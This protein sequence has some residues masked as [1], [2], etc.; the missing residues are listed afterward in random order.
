M[1]IGPFVRLLTPAL[2]S[3]SASS[4]ATQ[5]SCAAWLSH[6]AKSA[7]W[8]R[9]HS[10]AWVPESSSPKPEAPAEAT[11]EPLNEQ[12]S[13]QSQQQQQQ[14]RKQQTPTVEASQHHQ[15]RSLTSSL[16]TQSRSHSQLTHSMTAADWRVNET[17]LLENMHSLP[18]KHV[19]HVLSRMVM[20]PDPEANSLMQTRST[21]TPPTSMQYA[22]SSRLFIKQAAVSLRQHPALQQLLA[23]PESCT[24]LAEDSSFP[25][26]SRISSS[27]V[28]PSTGPVISLSQLSDQGGLSNSR[29]L[30]AGQTRIPAA[31]KDSSNTSTIST[32]SV[33]SLPPDEV[34]LLLRLLTALKLN[35]ANLCGL[36]LKACFPAGF[37]WMFTFQSSLDNA[38]SKGESAGKHA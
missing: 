7:E 13:Q 21:D 37:Q 11:L 27:V 17:L 26:T 29:T 34:L 12:H 25:L 6:T 8:L 9:K 20:A 30:E 22:P 2:E 1:R 36:V 23:Q 18:I 5:P 16:S 4:P 31:R 24:T 35:D 3:L 28:Q 38:I 15:V 33:A 10:A 19:M 14:Q 32:G